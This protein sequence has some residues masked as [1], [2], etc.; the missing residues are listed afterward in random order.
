[1]PRWAKK[2]SFVGNQINYSLL[3]ANSSGN[4]VRFDTVLV[5]NN[6]GRPTSGQSA[7]RGCQAGYPASH[8]RCRPA[9]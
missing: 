9:T 4:N 6:H 3:I 5:P 8:Q 1:M 7:W 2:A